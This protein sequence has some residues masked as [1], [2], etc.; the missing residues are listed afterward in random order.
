MENREL[1]EHKTCRDCA[2]GKK[3][4]SEIFPHVEEYEEKVKELLH[5]IEKL[6]C[7]FHEIASKIDTQN[8]KPEDVGTIKELKDRSTHLFQLLL[9]LK[10]GVLKGG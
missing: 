3:F 7:D 2:F 1:F 6:H 4:Y 5:D 8:P 10:R 9:A